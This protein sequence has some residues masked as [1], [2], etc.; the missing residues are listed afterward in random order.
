M[1]V[2]SEAYCYTAGRGQL[3]TGNL[4]EILAGVQPC[5]DKPFQVLHE[6]VLAQRAALSGCICILLAWDEARQAC[7]RQL[8]ALGVPLRAILVTSG[9]IADPPAWLIVLEPGKVQEGLGKL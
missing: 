5:S 8:H 6:A 4:L 2:G 7:V 9:A 3:Q 1:F